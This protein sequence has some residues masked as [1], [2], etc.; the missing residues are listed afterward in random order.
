MKKVIDRGK[1]SKTP[2]EV[3]P[4]ENINKNPQSFLEISSVKITSFT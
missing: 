4:V 2:S 3:K 1:R